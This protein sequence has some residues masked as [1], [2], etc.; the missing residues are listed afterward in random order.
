MVDMPDGSR[1]ALGLDSTGPIVYDL[2]FDEYM[3]LV[4]RGNRAWLAGDDGPPGCPRGL[5][6]EMVRLWC[7]HTHGLYIK[8]VVP[9]ALA[10][11]I[12]AAGA[13][14]FR[15]EA[16]VPRAAAMLTK[17]FL[18]A[19]DHV[20]ASLELDSCPHGNAALA[21]C[22]GGNVALAAD[23]S[24]GR[25]NPFGLRPEL[26]MAN[27]GRHVHETERVMEFSLL[28]SHEGPAD[29]SPRGSPRGEDSGSSSTEGLGGAG[30]LPME[31]VRDSEDAFVARFA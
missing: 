16:F 8:V 11:G 12:R 10:A 21:G 6:V 17:F 3:E 20:L 27:F 24:A 2:E 1:C 28:F 4:N 30:D 31:V 13:V 14:R 22:L 18:T 15:D 29:D 19:A 9:A 5:G 25:Y 7:A 23:M 26:C